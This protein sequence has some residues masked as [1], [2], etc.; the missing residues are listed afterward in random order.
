LL[1]TDM[2]MPDG[3]TG[4]QLA[5]QLQASKPDLKVI[6][7]TGYS[8]NLEGTSFHVRDGCNFLQKPYRPERL[9]KAIRESLDQKS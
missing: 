4:R 5:K 2:V 1:L 7:T 3:L 6:Y 8:I 9:F